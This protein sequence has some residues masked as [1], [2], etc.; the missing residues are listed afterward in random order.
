MSIKPEI[1]ISCD[2]GIVGGICIIEKNNL[3]KVYKIP[4][5]IIIVN[6]KKKKV[7]DL[8]KLV[9]IFEPYK[10]KQVLF[11]QEKVTAM[12]KQGVTSTFNFGKSAGSTLGI[13]AAFN[14]KIV[15]IRSQ[16]WKKHFLEL[17]TKEITKM[18]KEQ[19]KLII[20][21]KKKTQIDGE[22]KDKKSKNRSYKKIVDNLKKNLEKLKR[23]IKK[24]AKIQSR[25][26]AKK[27]YPELEEEFDKV[28]D[29]GKSDALLIGFFAKDYYDLV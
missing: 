17:E 3:P 14:W 25:Q 16:S 6:K 11:A 22:L 23:L 26:L 20:L 2:P 1:I 4:I 29:D 7:Y 13:A 24:E 12:R 9:D 8:E 10:N 5:K 18:R 15:E 19:K 21:I 27:F 28:S